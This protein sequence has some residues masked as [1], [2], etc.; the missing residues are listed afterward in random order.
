MKKIKFPR[1]QTKTSA[2]ITKTKIIDINAIVLKT[3]QK[4]VKVL[5]P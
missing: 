4:A 3:K 2:I 5:R 1:I